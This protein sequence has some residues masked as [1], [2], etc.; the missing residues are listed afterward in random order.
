MY[1]VIQIEKNVEKRENGKRSEFWDDCRVWVKVAS[2]SSYFITE[3]NKLTLIRKHKGKFCK[4]KNIQ[5]KREFIEIELQPQHTDVMIVHRLYQ[6]LKEKTQ[7][8]EPFK[9]RVTWIENPTNEAI[10]TD[11]A[12]VEYTGDFHGRSHHGLVKN[13]VNNPKIVRTKSSVR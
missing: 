5:G 13:D 10:Q 8:G 12:I 3:D 9:R 11:V 2:P 7:Q 6:T 4:S 1:Y